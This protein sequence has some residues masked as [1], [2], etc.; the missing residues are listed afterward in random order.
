MALA[1]R[2]IGA[3]MDTN[4]RIKQERLEKTLSPRL[5][6]SYATR[7]TSV[8]GVRT[9]ESSAVSRFDRAA[10]KSDVLAARMGKTRGQVLADRTGNS[11]P[12][13]GSVYTESPYNVLMNTRMYSVYPMMSRSYDPYKPLA[14]SS[15]GTI[16]DMRQ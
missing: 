15:Y 3:V 1:T 10:S 16:P 7:I 14:N 9:P 12:L 11:Q 8:N 6:E 4:Y 2:G 13:M 5:S